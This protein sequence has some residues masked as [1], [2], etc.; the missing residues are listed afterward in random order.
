MEMEWEAAP[1]R[2]QN[3][4]AFRGE[5]QSRQLESDNKVQ[6]ANSTKRNAQEVERRLPQTVENLSKWPEAAFMVLEDELLHEPNDFE[7]VHVETSF[8]K[9]TKASLEILKLEEEDGRGMG[10]KEAKI[11]RLDRGIENPHNCRCLF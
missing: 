4:R 2:D 10:R 7:N 8:R 11:M 6:I 1:N 3:E 9:R 5:N